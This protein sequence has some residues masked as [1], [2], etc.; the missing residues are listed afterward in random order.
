MAVTNNY[1]HISHKTPS[2]IYGFIIYIIC[3]IYAE[4][5]FQLK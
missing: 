4:L 1:G 3:Q 2:G 5:S